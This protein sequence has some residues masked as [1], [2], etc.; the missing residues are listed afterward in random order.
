MYSG[1]SIAG[2]K[3]AAANRIFVVD[4][5]PGGPAEKDGK[6]QQ[7][8]EILEVNDIGIRGLTHYEAS[9]ILKVSFNIDLVF[10]L[11]MFYF[12][13]ALNDITSSFTLTVSFDYQLPA[14]YSSSV[15]LNAR[16]IFYGLLKYFK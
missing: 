8:D 1:L 14:F 11:M 15:V 12:C 9:T 16:W 13:F 10:Y 2:G 7:A 4:V 3:G 5:K 6:I